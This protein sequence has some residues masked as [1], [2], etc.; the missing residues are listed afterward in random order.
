M[1]MKECLICSS[2]TEAFY[3][4]QFDVNF[5]KCPHCEFIARD[6]RKLLD[7]EGEK[8]VYDLH[9]NS[10]EN[11]GYV[12][13]FTDFIDESIIPYQEKRE[14]LRSFDFGSGPEPVFSQVLARDYGYDVDIY[15]KYYS[16]TKSY[17]GQVYDLITSTEVIEHL[18]DPVAYF[19]L[20]KEHLK[21]DGILAVM[22]LFHHKDDD[23]FLNWWYR[24]DLTHISFF[25]GRTME[26]MAELVGLKLLH[27]GKRQATF[28]QA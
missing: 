17:E 7:Q 12:K 22:T 13:M 10:I 28:T 14:G 25:T 5:Y 6:R 9:N 1:N 3:D 20:F 23:H 15:D 27:S 8:E 26:V 16:P 24:R 18:D 2:E 4:K 19:K 11:E 21:P